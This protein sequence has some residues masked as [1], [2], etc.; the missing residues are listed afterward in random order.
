[1]PEVLGDL[2][3]LDFSRV[4]A[5]PFATMLLGDFGATVLKVEK[6]GDGDLSRSWAPPYGPSGEATYFLS[7]NRNKSSIS[8]DLTDPEDLS[9]ARDLAL[10]ADVVVENFRPSV[11]DRLHLGYQELSKDNPRLV[12]CSITAFGSGAG[13]GL[14]GYD[15]LVQ[16]LGGLMSITGE[17][18]GAPQKVGVA[19]VDVLAGLFTTVGIFAALRHRDATGEG[20]R[21]EVDLL[22]SI[23]GALVN[24]AAAYSVAGIEPS[25]LGNAHPSIAPYE[26]FKCGGR[27]IVIAVGNERQ[28]EALCRVLGLTSLTEDERFAGN[29]ARVANR[30]ALR[31]A[32]EG[33]LC[34]GD[35]EDWVEKLV[36][37]GVPA[38][39]V[40]DIGAAF[41]LADRLG[42]A[43]FVQLRSVEGAPLRLARNPVRLSKTPVSYR[44]PPPGLS[45]RKA[46]K[47][48]S[49]WT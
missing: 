43:P 15:L 19:L 38:G 41:A 8:L 4:L 28:F 18:A 46:Q 3:V 1:M 21:V 22:S 13:A 5:G 48:T 29:P 6:P 33:A 49:S 37:S 40:N 9:L 42:L 25:R 2:K 34:A 47:G 45:A 36:M 44:L 35:P 14:P 31:S 27:D 7:V 12:Y 11:M 24:Q 23:L 20:Q 39:Q 10:Q 17:A 30:V 26:L 16:A 32:I